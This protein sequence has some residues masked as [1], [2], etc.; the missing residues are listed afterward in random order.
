M[1]PAGYRL[2]LAREGELEA[3][4]DIERRAAVRFAELGPA[5]EG[6]AEVMGAVVTPLLEL[7]RGLS[8]RGIFVA[9]DAAD[10]PVGFALVRRVDDDAHLVELDVLPE[11]GRK[12]LG[13]ALVVASLSW[14]V[15]RRL[16]RLT[17]ST[18]SFIPFNAPFYAS[19]GFVVIEDD[20]MGPELRA[21]VH[22]DETRGLPSDGRVVMARAL[23]RSI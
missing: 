23:P 17:L 2:R 8:D 15:S 22:D 16:R 6:L 12:G 18:L 20:A 7:E 5:A 3:C 9:V 10:A 19:L 1:I 4:I 21:L 13:R 11:H 14:G